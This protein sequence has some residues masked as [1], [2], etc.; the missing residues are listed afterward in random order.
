MNNGY[1]RE[2]T[3]CLTAEYLEALL[4]SRKFGPQ[5][6]SHRTIPAKVQ[7]ILP[8]LPDEL[9]GRLV[10][11]LKSQGIHGL[12]THQDRAI[13]T[14]WQ[15]KDILVATPTASGKSMIYNLPVI[16]D[17]IKNFPGNFLYI[18]PLKALA[19]DQLRVFESMLK[20]VAPEVFQT[21][22]LPAAIFDGDTSSYQ[23]R[24]I[25]KSA[26]RV[27][28]TNPEML[29]LSLL[30]YHGNWVQF[31][32]NLKYIV[33]DEI[34]IYRGIF[35][36]HMAWVLRRLQ[37][38]AAH[39]GASPQFI[40]LS[41][42]IGSP[43]LFTE[44]LTGKIVEILTESGAPQ[45]EKDIV[46]LN[47]WDSAASAAS[48]M[49]EAA[50]KRQLRTIVYTQ[51]RKMTEL[52][53]IW[54]KPRLQE[55]SEQLSAYRAGFLPEERREIEHKLFSG[56]LLGVISTSALELGID[57][58]NLDICI[59][60][61]YPGSMMAVWQ[62]AGRVGRSS[63][64]SL[65]IL[66]AQ[67]DAL[68]QYLMRMPEAFFNRPVES[69]V[70]NPDNSV[71]LEQHLQ[72]AAAELPL[73]RAEILPLST[74]VHASIQ[75]LLARSVLLQSADGETYYASRKY[76]QHQVNLRGGGN[77]LSII[78]A[79]S[80]EILG[81]ID[82]VRAIKECHPGA[83]YLHRSRTWVVAHLDI[84]NRE[85][86]VRDETPK[87]F[88]RP[89]VQK[90]TTILSCQ[91]SINYR[92]MRISYGKVLVAEK[93]TGFQKR[94][95]STQKLIATLSLDLPENSFETCGLWIE[96]PAIVQKTLEQ[97]KYHFMGAIHALEHGL[98]ALF[99]LLVLCDRNDI[100]G[101]ACPEHEQ[102]QTPTVFIYDGHV[103]GAGLTEEAFSKIDLLFSST[104]DM[105]LSCQCENGC[106]SCVHSPK[107]GSGNRPID[108]LA[109]IRLL[110]LLLQASSA[111]T[112]QAHQAADYSLMPSVS[113]LTQPQNSTKQSSD[114]P[115]IEIRLPERFGV[116]DI[117]T[118][119]SAE[120]VGGW[121]HSRNMGMAVGVIYD[122]L[123]DD[124]VVYLEDEAEKMI[125][126]LHELDLVV[127]FNSKRFDYQVLSQ[128]S[129]QHLEDL[130]T[131]DLL[132]LIHQH[133]GYRLSLDRIA[134]HTLGRKKTA[135]GLQ[136]LQWYKE[137]KIDLICKYCREDV[138]ITR[139]IFLFAY[140]NG[141]LLF[142]NKAEKSVRLPINMHREL[143]RIAR[144]TAS[145]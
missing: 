97:E 134:E 17:I 87:Y 47:P 70:V 34:H 64:K 99:P 69:A 51:S 36:S 114:E 27:L 46:L 60:V 58:G 19:Q 42:T 112:E 13:R 63:R 23:R 65:V 123:L 9:D 75:D 3:A 89:V 124:Y 92:Q 33:I 106:P 66:I 88:T 108:K 132:E 86:V 133:L 71:V 53:T 93:V 102:T 110:E 73:V 83:V 37:R 61:G 49:L 95:T 143:D 94:Q 119:R 138:K 44:K 77:Q 103:G 57:I 30:P 15:G 55:F 18:F 21:M 130:P 98:I 105:I 81:E 136:A 31:F 111:N 12:Y 139:D 74:Q 5:I 116:F 78:E 20:A 10:K 24:R 79:E 118:I 96:L 131:L 45:A 76:P 52:I 127:G 22:H 107:C 16:N 40:L 43:H 29:H 28:I 122:S 121:Q 120:E 25:R 135:D 6:V 14:V 1:P 137:G 35:G 54:T 117:E 144:K 128:Y 125:R 129:N 11:Y 50:I 7:D 101:I 85:I 4:G 38:I 142:Q 140:E 90:T 8:D 91:S 67:E 82:T 109:C 141:Y 104:Q 84:L 80:G 72:C 2:R 115:K 145:K 26:P 32:Q 39:Y 41:A 113:G 56:E 100:G 48:Q 62:R 68:D 59:L 126:H